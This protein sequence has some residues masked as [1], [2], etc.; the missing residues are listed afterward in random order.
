MTETDGARGEECTDVAEMIFERAMAKSEGSAERLAPGDNAH[1]NGGARS[2]GGALPSPYIVL[3][4]DRRQETP[5]ATR[6]MLTACLS[7]GTM[8]RS[9]GIVA[10]ARAL[11][12]GSADAACVAVWS[13]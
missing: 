9:S 8:A 7:M 6:N 12:Q 5:L 11:D 3:P 13:R 4:R 2:G 1:S 10:R